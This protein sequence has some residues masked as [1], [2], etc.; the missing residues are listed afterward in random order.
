MKGHLTFVRSVGWVVVIVGISVAT[1]K[2]SR[3]V[4]LLELIARR[5]P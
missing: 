5:L 4:E 1:Q 2:L 3:I